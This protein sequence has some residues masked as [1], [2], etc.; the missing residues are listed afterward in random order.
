MQTPINTI[1]FLAGLYYG[2][3]IHVLTELCIY[4]SYSLS[5]TAGLFDPCRYMG[6][7][8]LAS[9]LVMSTYPQWKKLFP[10]VTTSYGRQYGWHLSFFTLLFMGFGYA[11]AIVYPTEFVCVIYTNHVTY[12][13]DRLLLAAPC[14]MVLVSFAEMYGWNAGLRS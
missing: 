13:M 3:G 4:F 1:A 2:I 14:G 9:A 12:T 5:N 10:L 8:C 6:N 7:S 11:N